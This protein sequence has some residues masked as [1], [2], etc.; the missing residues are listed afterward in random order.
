MV[1]PRYPKRAASPSVLDPYKEQLAIGRRPTFT[2]TCV[3]D[4]ASRP[5]VPGPAD[6][7]LSRPAG[8]RSTSLPSAGSRRS[9]T[10]PLAWPLLELGE[11]FQFDWSC[12]YLFVGGFRKRLEASH[13][14]LAASWR[15]MVTAYFSEAHEMLFDAHVRAF[16]AF[17]GVPYRG[18]YDNMKTV[19]DKVGKG[20][21]RTVNARFAL[22]VRAGVLQP[23]SW[24]G[25]GDRREERARP[26]TWHLAGSSRA[27]LAR[28]GQPQCVAAPGL[29]GRLA[30]ATPSRELPELTIADVWQQEQASSDAQ[31]RT[32]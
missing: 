8:A 5:C 14:K 7:G 32:V 3:S 1:E 24:L 28:S 27:Q 2:A 9:Q 25:E 26:L 31:S 4:V 29:P 11:A 19:I 6:H 23:R 18:I 22:P 16:A 20:R 17:G 21:S 10:A 30:R 12:E 15:F 13:T